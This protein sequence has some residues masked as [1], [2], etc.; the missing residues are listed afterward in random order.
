MSHWIRVSD[1]KLLDCESKNGKCNACLLTLVR[2]K[3]V[4]E[5]GKVSLSE[6]KGKTRKTRKRTSNDSKRHKQEVT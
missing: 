6:K 5:R 2:H 3:L 1:S 4:H